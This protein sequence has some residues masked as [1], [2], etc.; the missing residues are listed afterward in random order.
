[1]L[2][3]YL[4]FS[5]CILLEQL[6]AVAASCCL[7]WKR[8][9]TDIIPEFSEAEPID[10]YKPRQQKMKKEKGRVV[11]AAKP[12]CIIGSEVDKFPFVPQ[13][14]KDQLDEEPAV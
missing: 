11:L 2:V 5:P 3:I 12:P 6:S 10:P 13:V 4:S 14:N 1:V 7:C 8:K 9:Y